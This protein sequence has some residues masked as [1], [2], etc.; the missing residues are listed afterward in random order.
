MS[1]AIVKGGI[2][3]DVKDLTEHDVEWA[4]K[5]HDCKL[6]QE[7]YKKLTVYWAGIVR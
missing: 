4:L 5:V 6:K 7:R 3:Y 1:L 2:G